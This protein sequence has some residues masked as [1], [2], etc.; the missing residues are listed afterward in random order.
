MKDSKKYAKSVQKLFRSLKRKQAKLKQT[1]YEDLIEALVYAA[2]LEYMT[3]SQ[4][5]AAFKRFDDYFVD[6]N[7]MRVSKPEEVM[8]MLGDDNEITRK[9]AN[10]AILILRSVFKK[11]NNMNL[12]SLQKLG[13]RQA[14]AV[15]EKFEAADSFIVDYVMLTALGGHAIPLNDNMVEYLKDNELAHPDA[16]KDEIAGFLTRQIASSNGYDFYALLRKESESKIKKTKKK[17]ATKKAAKKTVKKAKAVKKT[18]KVK[19]AK[20]TKKAKKKK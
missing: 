1:Q 19:K 13:K 17:K 12:E 8:D 15:I 14:K 4:T 18:K 7:D 10:N 6:F 2:V 3:E 11:Y 20:T 5:V 9:V 16:D